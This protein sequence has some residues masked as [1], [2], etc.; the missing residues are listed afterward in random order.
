MHPV[1]MYSARISMYTIWLTVKNAGHT[2]E[3]IS[4]S[5]LLAGRPFSR[6]SSEGIGMTATDDDEDTLSTRKDLRTLQSCLDLPQLDISHRLFVIQPKL[7]TPELRRLA[8]TN[9]HLELEAVQ[10]V[11]SVPGWGVYGVHDSFV[12]VSPR[13]KLPFGSGTLEVLKAA[14]R[15]SSDCTGIFLNMDRLSPLQ[16][17]TLYSVFGI[18]VFDRFT[19]AL[20]I[21]KLYANSKEAKIQAA[22]AE[23]KYL[24]VHVKSY[25]AGIVQKQFPKSLM[26]VQ[27]DWKK[28]EE[29]ISRREVKLKEK[30][31]AVAAQRTLLRQNAQRRRF[32]L[33]AV[34]G[35]TNCGK[36]SLIR[37]LSENANLSGEDRFFATLDVTTH[38]GKLPC[39][40]PVLYAD[41]VGFFSD[42]PMDL[43]PS[44]N[45]TLEE[46][47]YAD[48]V[49]HVI[50]RS[51][52]NW[53]FQRQSVARTLDNLAAACGARIS[54]VEVWNKSDKFE[55]ESDEERPKSMIVISCLT[56][57]GMSKLLAL[58]EDR[59]LTT[60]A[61]KRFLLRIPITG[62]YLSLLYSIG[63]VVATETLPTGD[64]MC[65]SL[66]TQ[67]HKVDKLLK[68]H[69]DAIEV[70]SGPSTA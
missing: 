59:I 21:F 27:V 46:I 50:D 10:L 58:I 35:Y 16:H 57:D 41:T 18:P 49:L 66:V 3:T 25:T 2:I 39:R 67:Q 64:Q 60:T 26:P 23:L 31:K 54:P 37:C 62:G 6:N 68:T 45:S 65:V 63:S 29:V 11:K 19:V 15:K 47:T 13:A 51:N 44:F 52:P 17:K 8:T 69:P 48:L 22:L 40:L 7:P 20:Q 28:T 9:E 4:R 32:P 14:I 43:M 56:R 5:L 30:L 34:V 70:M 36:T 38:V 53:R 61:Y 24:K 12:K 55:M 33:V 42:L 1:W